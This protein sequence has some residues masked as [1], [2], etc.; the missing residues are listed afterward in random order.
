MT[1]LPL[2]LTLTAALRGGS[3]GDLAE[4]TQLRIFGS[5]G[6]MLVLSRFGLG[7]VLLGLQAWETSLFRHCLLA[8]GAR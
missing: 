4:A 2:L 3:G 6:G 5:K 1:T 8:P 7:S